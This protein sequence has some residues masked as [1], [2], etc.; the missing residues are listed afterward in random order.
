MRSSSL[1]Q[2]P[3]LIV[4]HWWRRRRG[5]SRLRWRESE[6]MRWGVHV[7]VCPY[8]CALA[9]DND[10]DEGWGAKCEKQERGG[11]V[12]SVN[13]VWSHLQHIPSS[14][15]RT[16]WSTLP[17]HTHW[18]PASLG[19]A[20]S[21]SRIDSMI[22]KQRDF[23]LGLNWFWSR[24]NTSERFIF[25]CT[26]LIGPDLLQRAH[27]MRG[28]SRVHTLI[29]H[30]PV[31]ERGW[32][33]QNRTVTMGSNPD[34]CFL[35]FFSSLLPCSLPSFTSQQHLQMMGRGVEGRPIGALHGCLFPSTWHARWNVT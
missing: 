32:L 18:C 19:L 30:L 29:I 14:D 7:S 5:K 22:L 25:H 17:T 24:S 10:E 31:F 23:Y 21:R 15:K 2:S 26:S 8:L 6:L 33:G 20:R 13:W 9:C 3:E 1:R 35:F 12:G 34:F 28:F 4:P 27:S 16:E 11:V